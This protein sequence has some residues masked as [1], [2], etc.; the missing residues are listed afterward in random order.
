MKI[1]FENVNVKTNDNNKDFKKENAIDHEENKND[2]GDIEA[3]SFHYYEE[4]QH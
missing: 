4:Y 1:G 3:V 2:M